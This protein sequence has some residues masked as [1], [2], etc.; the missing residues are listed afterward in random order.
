MRVSQHTPDGLPEN[1]A[2]DAAVRA[3]GYPVLCGVDEAG[4]GPLCGPVFAAAVVLSPGTMI[5]GLTDSKKLSESRRES[6]FDEICE[7]AA[8]YGIGSASVEEI[9]RY[10]ILQATF[11][12]MTRAVEALP[13]RPD[14]VLVD[15][16][17]APAGLSLPVRTVVKGD[18]LSASVAAA[19]ILAK[20]SRDRVLRALDEVY[21]EYGFAKHKGYG[22]REQYA[23]IDRYGPTPEHRLSFLK[24]HL[25]GQ[26]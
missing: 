23:A 12:A 5:G 13:L 8:G 6:L 4:R 22:T 15:G 7:R 3:E 21:P 9:E 10:N 16:N 18:L 19:S 14:L 11:L 26:K 25:N 17:R 24:K 20:V 2:F 1:W